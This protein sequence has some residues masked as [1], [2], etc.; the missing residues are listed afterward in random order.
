MRTTLYLP[1]ALLATITLWAC[2][3]EDASP[4]EAEDTNASQV[5]IAHASIVLMDVNGTTTT[6]QS[7]GGINEIIS[8]ATTGGPSP[9][10]SSAIFLAGF[11]NATDTLFRLRIGTLEFTGGNPTTLELETFLAPGTRALSELVGG[12]DG[13]TLEWRDASG[14]WFGTSCGPGAVAA[15]FAIT[16]IAAQ[17]IGPEHYVK[18]R[19]VFSGTFHPCDGSAGDV[20]VSDGVLV[21]RVRDLS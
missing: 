15:S 1:C 20:I 9:D 11:T 10:T 5:D 13:L 8:T 2:E 17:Q 18:F 6:L 12:N 3:K 16:H 21:L 14:Q 19:A 4:E 7:G